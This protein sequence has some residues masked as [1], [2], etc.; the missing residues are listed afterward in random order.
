[1]L[2]MPFQRPFRF[3]LKAL[4]VI[5]H[6]DGKVHHMLPVGQR[7]RAVAMH[8]QR[9]AAVGQF[10]DPLEATPRRRIVP[11]ARPVVENRRMLVLFG[12]FHIKIRNILYLKR[13]FL[14]AHLVPLGE[15]AMRRMDFPERLHR[16]KEDQFKMRHT[17]CDRPPIQCREEFFPWCHRYHL[18]TL[19]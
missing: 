2:Q 12:D 18:Y 1:M 10:F 7:K 4:R 5:H 8:H 11:S 17:P 9:I 13:L 6:A 19:L 16:Q 15:M 14:R 3:I